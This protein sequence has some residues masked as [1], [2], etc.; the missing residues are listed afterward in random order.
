MSGAILLGLRILIGLALY[1]FLA[2]AL[3]LLWQD[4]R[5]R[6]RSMLETRIPALILSM[7]DSDSQNWRFNQA[8]AVL[9]RDPACDC[10]IDDATISARHAR[11][12]Y[13]HGQWWIEDLHSKN[14]T[15]LNQRP[16]FEQVVLT[17]EDILQFGR[18]IFRIRMEE[19]NNLPDSQLNP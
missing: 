15:L 10:R 14:G 3:W 17:S 7:D 11:F 13:H 5:R 6:G 16:V 2:W 19:A 9:G 12:S 8:T 18:V 1:L 4:L